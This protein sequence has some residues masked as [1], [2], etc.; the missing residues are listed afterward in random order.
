MSEKKE[1]KVKAK[2]EPLDMDI[3]DKPHQVSSVILENAE[4]KKENA[5]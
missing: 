5:E 3:L 1:H 4:A 2:Q